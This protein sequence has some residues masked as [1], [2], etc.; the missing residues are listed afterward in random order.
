LNDATWDI[1][2]Q[3]VTVYQKI[4]SKITNP[5]V[6]PLD[7]K[8][9][10]KF[11]TRGIEAGAPESSKQLLERL[12]V[13][14]PWLE[15]NCPSTINFGDLHL[16]NT[17]SRSKSPEFGKLVLIDPIPRIGPWVFDPAYCQI[18]STNT[19]INLVA[20][21]AKYRKQAGLPTGNQKHLDKMTKLMLGWLGIMWWGLASKNRKDRTWVQK[22][23]SYI[24]EALKY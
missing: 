24:E 9:F 14:W 16:K 6:Y 4:A 20:R 19:D 17:L 21:V 5:E 1:I 12:D 2:A 10:T 22:T 13:D 11:L 7:L 15:E 8:G 3:T 18:I 23:T